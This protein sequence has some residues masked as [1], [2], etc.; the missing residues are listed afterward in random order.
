MDSSKQNSVLIIVPIYNESKSIDFI[1]KDL[2]E[3]D[4][5]DVIFVNDSSKDNSMQLL[6]D[7]GQLVINLPINLGIGGCI[8]TG[9]KYAFK[10]GYKIAIQYDGDG[11]HCAEYIND[12]VNE[13]K[14]GVD[15]VIGSR[16]VESKGFQST[17]ARRLGIRILSGII[18]TISGKRLYDVTSGFRACN[19][20]V[21]GLFTKYYPRDY[22]EPEVAGAL[23]KNGYII[24]EIPVIMRQRH[25]G[26]SS[27]KS[28][29]SIY[30][31]IKVTIAILF[32]S[33]IYPKKGH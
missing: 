13:I 30:Y 14:N 11:Q 2:S 27:I 21:I 7:N 8:Q 26:Q 24:S 31:M 10:Q 16:F 22:P 1:L 4:C 29:L 33:F 15:Y 18:R 25:E 6:L 5:C 20:N 9:Y 32:S 28:Y 3:I 19:R 12:L 23:A 17:K